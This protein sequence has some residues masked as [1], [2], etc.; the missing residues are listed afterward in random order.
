VEIV[1]PFPTLITMCP[2]WLLSLQ[3]TSPPRG[4]VR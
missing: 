3:N 1:Q 2:T 4:G